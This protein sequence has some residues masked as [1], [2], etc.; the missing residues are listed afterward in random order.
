MMKNI[1]ATHSPDGTNIDVIP[2]LQIIKDIMH[3]SHPDANIDAI[4]ES[5]IYHDFNEMFEV[6][7]LTINK[8]ACE[9][10]CKCAG[11]GDTHATAIGI[12]NTLSNYRWDAKVVITLAAFAVNYGEFW[13]VAQ[14]HKTNPL[15]KSLALLKQLPD[16]LEHRESLKTRFNV[17]NNLVKAMFGVTHIIIK[18]KEL[19]EQ[20]ISPSTPE[21]VTATTHIP[22]AIYWIIRSIVACASVL[23]NL[24]GMGHEYVI[25][26][27]L[28]L[29]YAFSI[30]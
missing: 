19:P 6:L 5:V 21:L 22:T 3:R 14:L 28:L 23:T 9:I 16:V 8:V 27:L 10:A 15:A 25:I 30:T 1:L 29:P 26:L 12:F 2:L 20:Y 13:L 18:F 17:V 24:I 11:G 4:V 7:A